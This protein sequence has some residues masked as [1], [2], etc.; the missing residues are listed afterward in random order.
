MWAAKRPDHTGPCQL[1]RCCDT[2][3]TLDPA[4][5]AASV[6]DPHTSASSLAVAATLNCQHGDVG[7]AADVT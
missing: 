5:A 6:P 3:K 1:T 2:T 7:E 4:A